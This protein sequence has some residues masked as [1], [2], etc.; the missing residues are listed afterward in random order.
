MSGKTHLGRVARPLASSLVPLAVLM[1]LVSCWLGPAGLIRTIAKPDD[2]ESCAADERTNPIVKD[3]VTRG[4]GAKRD[5]G[6][7]A[8]QIIAQGAWAIPLPVDSYIVGAGF[9]DPDYGGG[10]SGVDF[11]APRNTPI[12]AASAGK[13]IAAGCAPSTE[14]DAGSCDV[15]GSPAVKGCGWFVEILHADGIATMYCHLVRRPLVRT[16][17]KVKMGQHIGDLGTS[18]N[19]SEAHLHFQVHTDG[20]TTDET[21]IDP[22]EFLQSAGLD[23]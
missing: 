8:G 15:N 11:F 18:G 14:R 22:I 19:S 16:G 2:G 5:R 23:I 10:H 3:C 20:Q 17:Y 4:S 13:V 21:A 9:E 7:S 12:S 1:C 6:L